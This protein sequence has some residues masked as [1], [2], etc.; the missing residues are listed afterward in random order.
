MRLEINYRKKAVIYTNTWML[1]TMLPNN[2]DT[3]EEI[4]E[5]IKTYI[6]TSDN[7]NT[8][9]HNLW[10][11]EKAVLREKFVAIQF[12]F[13]KQKKSQINNI[14]LRL[15]QPEKEEQTIHKVSRRKEVIKIR[16]ELNEIETKK[17]IAEINETK[18][19][20]FFFVK[21]KKMDKSLVRLTKKKW[22]RIQINKNKNEKREVT[23][24]TTEIQ[25]I[26]RDYHKQL[27]A[28][29]RDNLEE[30]DKFLQRY[31]LQRLYQEEIENMNRQITTNKIET[32]I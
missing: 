15:K 21:I 16:A 25:R 12:Y 18:S 4:K 31:N 17:T 23:T 9:T 2:E 32:A 29:K 26:I 28:N 7:E 5:E 27:Y 20:F 30:M 22:E 10:D 6:Q 8:M 24:D 19:C 1:N 14:T 13:Q 3:T 11:A